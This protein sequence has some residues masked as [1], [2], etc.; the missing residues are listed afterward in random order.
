MNQ[1]GI[2]IAGVAFEHLC[3]HFVLPYSNWEFVTLAYS[4][5]F[6]ALS[7]GLQEGLW[8]LGGVPQVHRTDSMTAA[9]H[10]LRHSRGRGF[11]ARYLELL[12]HYGMKPSKIGVTKANEQGDVEQAHNRFKD[13]VDQRLRLRGSRDFPAKTDYHQFLRELVAARNLNRRGKLQEELERMKPLPAWKL[14]TS[15]EIAVRV[16]RWSTVNLINNVYSVPSRLR[17]YQL[18]ARVHACRIELEYGGQVVYELERLRGRDQQK[19]DYRHLIHSLIRKPGAFRRFV[20][21][22]A[23]FPSVVF[24]KA[25]DVL[26]ERSEKWADLQYI[27][28]LHLAATTMEV[29]VEEALSKLLE[30]GTVPEYEAVKALVAPPKAIPYPQVE[31]P[32]PDLSIYD[33]LLREE[34]MA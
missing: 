21:R 17:G 20:Y 3:Y 11:N 7:E 33:G 10:D 31:I 12:G 5:S 24:R 15:R 4:E 28:I 13:M 16:T 22:E 23:L 25:Y 18:R 27:Q 8:T 14:D 29:E 1:L 2:T 9:T 6:E 26:V 32:P 19:I 30:E 34:A